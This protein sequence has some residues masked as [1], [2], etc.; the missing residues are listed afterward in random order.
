[1]RS[2]IK[3]TVIENIFNDFLKKKKVYAYKKEK[4]IIPLDIIN[5]KDLLLILMC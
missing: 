3:P 4:I 2:L 1:M 5:D